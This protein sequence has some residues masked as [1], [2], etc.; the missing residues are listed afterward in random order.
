MSDDVYTPISR[1]RYQSLQGYFKGLPQTDGWFSGSKEEQRG[2]A[3]EMRALFSVNAGDDPL[4]I[5]QGDTMNLADILQKEANP[6]T[7]DELLA[8]LSS[9]L[10]E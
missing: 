2:A 4:R 1:E 10:E 5:K 3:D 6:W 7:V 9:L 8:E